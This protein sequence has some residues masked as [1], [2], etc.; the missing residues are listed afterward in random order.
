[1]AA[2]TTKENELVAAIGVEQS[3]NPLKTCHEEK[4]KEEQEKR[5]EESKSHYSTKKKRQCADRT[6]HAQYSTI[7][8]TAPHRN[9]Y[10]LSS[11]SG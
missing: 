10:D 11:P 1:M 4:E 8:T 2:L 6:W 7:T 3:E 5:R 9:M